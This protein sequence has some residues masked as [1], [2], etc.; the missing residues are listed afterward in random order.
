M[1]TINRS[2]SDEDMELIREAFRANVIRLGQLIRDTKNQIRIRKIQRIL[3]KIWLQR[4]G[5]EIRITTTE[6][7]LPM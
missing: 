3:Y 2:W 1:M 5:G 6:H 4:Y 7:G